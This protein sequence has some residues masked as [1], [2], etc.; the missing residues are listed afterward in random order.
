VVIVIPSATANKQALV[1]AVKKS[2]GAQVAVEDAC[3]I[4]KA[5]D[6]AKVASALAA[7]QGVD[8]VAVARKVSNRFSDVIKAVVEEGTRAILPKEKFYV[9][10]IQ[11]AKAGYVDRDIEFAST[12]ALVGRLAE[13]N[14]L[15][16][17]RESEAD[18]VIL[19]L[20]GKRSAYVGV[21]GIKGM[22]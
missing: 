10:V 9:R 20:V 2:C 21:K 1:R 22:T 17:K 13:I 18:R 6:P 16:A 19:V 14:T 4:C 8:G 15:P 7:L 3:I 11:T 12:G 5:G